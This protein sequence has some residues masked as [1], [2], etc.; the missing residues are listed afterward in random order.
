LFFQI[1]KLYFSFSQLCLNLPHHGTWLSKQS[2]TS[3]G[4][5]D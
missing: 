1:L 4:H 3:R 5:H 2:T